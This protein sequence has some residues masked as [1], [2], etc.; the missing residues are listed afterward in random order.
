MQDVLEYIFSVQVVHAFE[1]GGQQV[2]PARYQRIL[3]TLWE[4]SAIQKVRACSL[5]SLSLAPTQRE[6]VLSQAVSKVRKLA[7]P[8]KYVPILRH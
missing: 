8:D 6:S 2:Y 1:L 5:G 4:D 3:Q 7:L